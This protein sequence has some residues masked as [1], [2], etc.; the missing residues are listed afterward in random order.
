[1]FMLLLLRM[2]MLIQSYS[3]VAI[4]LFNVLFLIAVEVSRISCSRLSWCRP[5]GL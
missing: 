5:V 4:D 1:M 3:T 2:S